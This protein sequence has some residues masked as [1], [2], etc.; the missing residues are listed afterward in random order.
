MSERITREEKIVN[1][2]PYLNNKGQIEWKPFFKRMSIVFFIFS[3][4]VMLAL[5][6]VEHAI[7]ER[8]SLDPF[9]IL[10]KEGT[11]FLILLE[12]IVKNYTINFFGTIRDWIDIFLYKITDPFFPNNNLI[13]GWEWLGSLK[14]YVP[15]NALDFFTPIE[16][17]SLG[18]KLSAFLTFWTTMIFFSFT[19]LQMRYQRQLRYMKIQH[20]FVG[21]LFI[22]YH[23]A[24]KSRKIINLNLIEELRDM[25]FT[26]DNEKFMLQKMFKIKNWE[27]Y[28]IEEN[29]KEFDLLWYEYHYYQYKAV[30]K[31]Q[32][33]TKNNKKDKNPTKDTKKNKSNDFEH[34][35]QTQSI[36]IFN[37]ATGGSEDFTFNEPKRT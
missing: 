23:I 33:G 7:D 18:I 36:E 22:L 25:N 13:Q 17:V 29:A 4:P 30:L 21:K 11:Q 2:N 19:I 14:N 27:D 8:K 6:T 34:K 9:V 31:E 35:T 24:R 1:I 37:N 16:N 28:K 32:K 12:Y 3:G 20:L 10:S 5:I 26:K 15:R